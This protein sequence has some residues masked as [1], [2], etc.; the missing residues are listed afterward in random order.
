MWI[1]FAVALL[2]F[3]ITIVVHEL[4]HFF[5]AR[6]AGVKVEVFSIGFGP[7]LFTFWRDKHGTEWILAPLPLGG[8]VKMKGQED[9]P[10]GKPMEHAPDSFLA[11]GPWAR[12]SIIVAGVVMNAVFSYLLLSMAYMIGVP[13][14]D[15][16][17]AGAGPGSPAEAVGFQFGDEVVSVDGKSIES[18]EDLF[19][20]QA[21]L[22]PGREVN[23]E[24]VREGKRLSYRTLAVADREGGQRR[25]ATLGLK[26]LLT[27][28]IIE[29]P[30]GSPAALA[31]LRT[32]DAIFSIAPEGAR[33]KAVRGAEAVSRFIENHPGG[34]VEL[35]FERLGVKKAVRVDLGRRAEYLSG[36]QTLAVVDPIKGSPAEKAGILPG[37]RI[38]SLDGVPIR[39][40]EDMVV[41]LQTVPP[42]SALRLDVS[43]AGTNR[44]LQVIPAFN[45]S[46]EKLM[47][48]VKPSSAEGGAR[49]RSISWVAP[50]MEA[51]PG[52]VR[53]GDEI[54]KTQM[55]KT[56]LGKMEWSVYRFG[57]E[58]QVSIPLDRVETRSIGELAPLSVKE[59]I[60][61]YGVLE[62]LWKTGG[63][64]PRELGE[65]YL[66][67]G[68]F[69]SGAFSSEYV[70]GPVRIFRE[71]ARAAK[72]RGWAFFFLLFAKIG[73][74]LA[75]LNLLPIPGL[76]G[77]HAVFIGW[78]IATGK[79]APE[80][81]QRGV[82]AVGVLLLLMLASFVL[83]NDISHLMRP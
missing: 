40:W 53:V 30:V 68:R 60:V 17:I 52:G 10:T 31:G 6:R 62:S 76:D 33:E 20:R 83:F 7:R 43:R 2:G 16:R 1:Y 75:V 63:R 48:G 28:V 73:F 77:S 69:A 19:T 51:W 13:F 81:V 12:L 61:R 47:L 21:F 57:R 56:N 38:D 49:S 36:V 15:N 46:E 3:V 18:W 67:L 39:G 41:R 78:E 26:P 37:D 64:I 50:W 70:M 27:P 71:S 58:V 59:K 32:G 34:R 74:S 29:C 24:V 23:V 42:G 79:P 9:L 55:P 22:S 11:K 14:M 5:M 54:S 25:G 8:Y 35:V 82:Q 44:I 66:F 80:K 4:G 65:V 45:P 72:D